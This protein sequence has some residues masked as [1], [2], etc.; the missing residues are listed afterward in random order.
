MIVIASLLF[1][2][3]AFAWLHFRDSGK[4]K[5]HRHLEIL[6]PVVLLG[7]LL[8]LCVIFT[9]F[10]SFLNGETG[11]TP[12]HFRRGELVFTGR[13]PMPAKYVQTKWFGLV[14]EGEWLAMPILESDSFDPEAKW[15]YRGTNGK[16]HEVSP[17]ITSPENF[18]IER[19]ED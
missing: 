4:L 9:A 16:W 5:P 1:M 19:T 7:L 3:G 17:W 11:T 14:K 12:A 2:F 18:E 15:K 8:S 6:N 13:V 10:T